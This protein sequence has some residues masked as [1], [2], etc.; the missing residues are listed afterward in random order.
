MSSERSV[1]RVGHGAGR[2]REQ[3]CLTKPGKSLRASSL[4]NTEGGKFHSDSSKSVPTDNGPYFKQDGFL[5]D[6]DQAS[7]WPGL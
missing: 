3:E 5:S 7:P 6:S 1:Q 2:F 4:Q